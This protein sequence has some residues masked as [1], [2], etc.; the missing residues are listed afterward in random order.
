VDLALGAEGLSHG[1]R[2]VPLGQIRGFV[3][4]YNRWTGRAWVEVR[5]P[6]WGVPIAPG[7][8]ELRSA[9][10]SALPDRPFASEWEDGRFPAAPGGMPVEPV[11]ATAVALAAT[12][13]VGVGWSL[14]PGAG[15]CVAFAASWPIS[16]LRD[17][18]VVGASGLR[19][20]PIWAPS[21][22][23][24]DVR[25]VSFERG[26][27]SATVWARTERGVV[28]AGVPSVLIPALRARIRRLGGLSLAEGPPDVA[29]IYERWRAPA[30]GIPWGILV[31]T[32]LAS[33]GSGEPWTVLRQGLI[34]AAATAALGQSVEA[35]ATGWGF[36]AVGWLT[37]LY[38]G[39]L[40]ILAL[41]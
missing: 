40:A 32:L 8:G 17:A 20:G 31:G 12:A 13:A 4:H 14:G 6:G 35:R 25:E 3:E 33:W 26:S 38:A 18:I 10:R 19:A 39:F 15:A 36:G 27:R 1:G 28:C 5:G 37:V 29:A 22:P 16:R 9:L 34:V 7:W 24:E 23:W 2:V 21:I 41:S 30:D 11:F